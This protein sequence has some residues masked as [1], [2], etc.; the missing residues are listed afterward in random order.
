MSSNHDRNELKAKLGFQPNESL[1]AY[2]KRSKNDKDLGRE[3][4]ELLQALRVSERPGAPMTN[5]DV[6]ARAKAIDVAREQAKA[7]EAEK[8]A[9]QAEQYRGNPLA[10]LLASDNVQ[11]SKKQRAH[12][13]SVA[14]TRATE[15]E[16]Q[17][18]E[19]ERVKTILSSPHFATAM[20]SAAKLITLVTTDE[21]HAEASRLHE[22]LKLGLDVKGFYVAQTDLL[23]RMRTSLDAQF[24]GTA[25]DAMAKAAEAQRLSDQITRIDATTPAETPAE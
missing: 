8:K 6:I 15:L 23:A 19:D 2:L 22:T 17:R 20:D 11:L 1:D 5:R 13:E 10:A 14:A 3:Q 9:A 12:L 18:Q 24:T 4:S 7:R 21:F 16:A 25:Q